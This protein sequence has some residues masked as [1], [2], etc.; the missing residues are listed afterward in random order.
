MNKTLAIGIGALVLAA[1]LLWFLFTLGGNEAPLAGPNTIATGTPFGTGEGI[2]EGIPASYP[3]F[4]GEAEPL[5]L[6]Q[7]G[8][9]D[10]G[11][12]LYKLEASPVAGFVALTQGATTTVRYA[13]R[14]TGNIFDIRLPT[15]EKKRLTN[16]TLPQI[17]EAYFRDDGAAALFRSL[18]ESDAVKNMSIALTPPKATSTDALYTLS[19]AL[20]R[21]QIDG[22]AK[23]AGGTLLY[24]LKD[25]NAVVSSAWSGEKLATLWSGAF[26]SWRTARLG[27]GLLIYTKP[28]AALPGYAYRVSGGA[29]AKLLGPLNGLVVGAN[30]T[31]A[32]LIYSYTDG[33][34]T[35]LFAQEVGKTATT[36]FSP[37]TLADKCA[38]STREASVFYC[39]APAVGVQGAEPDMWYQGKAHFSDS[40]WRFDAATGA[41]SLV[42]EPES[43]FGVSLDFSL[44]EI[45][46][47]GKYFIFINKSDLSL[48]AIALR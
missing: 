19:L 1:G 21:G 29:L 43:D 27:S 12:K 44:P 46:L 4:E 45:S 9:V 28:A 39:G 34:T 30:P 7:V 24:V 13:D 42:L 11:V 25:S 47:D 6:A 48:W 20:L 5:P 40:L 15:L 32:R 2:Q 16:N 41:A 17:Y 35:R 37:G 18:D 3:D 33:N 26:G 14:A 10:E 23:G 8:V 22:I 36:E 31:G 38:A